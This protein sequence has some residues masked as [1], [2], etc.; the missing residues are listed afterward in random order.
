[1][2]EQNNLDSRS[3]TVMTDVLALVIGEAVV[4][5]LVCIGYGLADLLDLYSFDYRIITGAL[6]GMVVIV[7][8]YIFLSMAIDKELRSFVEKRGTKEMGDEEAAAF[9]K[10][11]SASIQK[12]IR[13]SGIIRT[14]S[15]VFTLVVAFLS[16]QFNP[17]ATAI[18][19]FAMRPVITAIELIRARSNPKPDPSKFI[20]YDFDEENKDEEKEDN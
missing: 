4:A 15:I 7:A 19:M 16:K 12:A 2:A 10:E 20:K 13:T 1:M 18:P 5:L 11:N 9:A 8:N 17:L 14:A 6:L 3:K